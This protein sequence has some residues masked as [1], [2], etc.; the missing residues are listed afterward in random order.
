MI[1]KV[2][3]Y[4]DNAKTKGMPILRWIPKNKSK[5]LDFAPGDSVVLEASEADRFCNTYKW[6][7][8]EFKESAVKKKK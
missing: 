1:E 7:K 3:T 4:P 6:L 2:V 5:S 8:C